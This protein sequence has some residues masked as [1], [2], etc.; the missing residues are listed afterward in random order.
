MDHSS[1]QVL[2]QAVTA[3]P[4]AALPDKALPRLIA[5][6]R[7]CLTNSPIGWLALPGDVA[8]WSRLA[9]LLSLGK[10]RAREGS[11]HIDRADLEAACTGSIL[12]ALLPDPMET[13]LRM[14]SRSGTTSPG[15]HGAFP[16][17]AFCAPHRSMTGAISCQIDQL[18]DL[19]QGAGIAMVAIGDVLVHRATRRPLADVLT[20]LREGCTIDAI[21]ERRLTNATCR[22]KSGYDLARLSHRY[23]GPI[24]RTVE[25]AEQC[26]LRLDELRYH[27]PDEALDGEPAQARPARP[28]REGLDW[29]Y[30][31]GPPPRIMRQ[32]DHRHHCHFPDH[33]GH[34]R[35]V[36]GRACH[37]WTRRCLLAGGRNR[38]RTS[39]EPSRIVPGH[40]RAGQVRSRAHPVRPCVAAYRHEPRGHIGRRPDPRRAPCRHQR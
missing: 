37:R 26:A 19:A 17:A 15:W 12:I 27:Y 33:H 22:P 10:R 1:P 23:P 13:P 21:D 3:N 39:P 28:A 18:A 36:F 7:L 9:W 29:R 5:S 31:S 4:R 16:D 24:R 6:T 34:R 40:R 35:A 14:A 11:C 2:P 30:P 25:I 32:P 38:R 8:A 20:C